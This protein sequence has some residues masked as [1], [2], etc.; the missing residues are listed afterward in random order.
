M[1]NSLCIQNKFWLCSWKYD[2]DLVLQSI[3]HSIDNEQTSSMTGQLYLN[4]WWQFAEHEYIHSATA[5]SSIHFIHITSGQPA[6]IFLCIYNRRTASSQ[7]HHQINV[8]QDLRLCRTNKQRELMEL[9]THHLYNRGHNNRDLITYGN[10]VCNQV[11]KAVSYF[12]KVDN[13]WV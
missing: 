13:E 3:S 6:A 11:L 5:C 1:L 7:I 2:A 12:S 8:G 9:D 4:R 10:C